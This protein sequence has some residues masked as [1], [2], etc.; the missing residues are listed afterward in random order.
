MLVK[1]WMIITSELLNK[2]EL[3]FLSKSMKSGVKKI[4]Y[5]K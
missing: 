3:I 4:K 2:V 1:F 5:K